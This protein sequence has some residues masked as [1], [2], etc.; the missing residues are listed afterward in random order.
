MLHYPFQTNFCTF[1][2]PKPVKHQVGYAWVGGCRVLNG[3]H[4][5]CVIPLTMT[6]TRLGSKPGLPA[7]TSNHVDFPSAM[8]LES[9]TA[10]G[11][12]SA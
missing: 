9:Q 12:I 10:R 11:T 4:C 3:G 7:Q 1:E 6:S 2:Q 8:E 5:P